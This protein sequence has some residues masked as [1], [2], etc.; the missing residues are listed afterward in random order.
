MALRAFTK[1]L[2]VFERRKSSCAFI[3]FR[4]G[5][6][7]EECAQALQTKLFGLTVRRRIQI[8][9][10]QSAMLLYDRNPEPF[11]ILA[12]FLAWFFPYL[13]YFGVFL[14]E[15]KVLRAGDLIFVIVSQFSVE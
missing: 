2:R 14:S 7:I 6:K 1:N 15:E 3:S 8:T 10:S 4:L 13:Q 12:R 9:L 5:P 11:L